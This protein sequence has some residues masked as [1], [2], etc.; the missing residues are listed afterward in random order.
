M[1]MRINILHYIVYR[2]HTLLLRIPRICVGVVLQENIYKDDDFG[3]LKELEG[4]AT[5][6]CKN[7]SVLFLLKLLGFIDKT[8][9]LL[10]PFHKISSHYVQ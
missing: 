1:E 4:E 5:G 7:I 3:Q 2:L 10:F 8:I 6:K 9:A